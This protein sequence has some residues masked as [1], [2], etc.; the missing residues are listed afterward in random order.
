MV[1]GWSCHPAVLL[2]FLSLSPSG[3]SG[4]CAACAAVG[5]PALCQVS[6]PGRGLWWIRPARSRWLRAGWCRLSWSV[7]G[8]LPWGWPAGGVGRSLAGR[9]ALLRSVSGGGSSGGWPSV[10]VC[11]R[12]EDIIAP[13]GAKVNPTKPQR[14]R[15]VF[16]SYAPNK[17]VKLCKVLLWWMVPPSVASGLCLLAQWALPW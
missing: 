3:R 1:R 4:G 7:A 16:V 6:T 12:R 13:S 9:W 5:G 10:W 15:A 8:G 2:S 17:T 11:P 14:D